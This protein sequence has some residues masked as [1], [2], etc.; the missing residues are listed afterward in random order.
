MDPHFSILIPA[1]HAEQWIERCLLSA[2][3]QDYPHFCVFFV[4]DHSADG[5]GWRGRK[6]I[7]DHT[8]GWRVTHWTNSERR[9]ILA[10]QWDMI[11]RCN[12]EEIAVCLD[13]DDMLAH[14][15]VLSHLAEVYR[16]PNVWLTYGSFEYDKKSRNPE[17]SAA[18]I[19]RPIPAN[20]H[21]RKAGWHCSHLKTFKVWLARRINEE[22]LK[23]NGEWIDAAPD[24]ALM[25]PLIEMAGPEHARF[26]PEILYSYNA[27]NLLSE[28]RIKPGWVRA[29][30]REIMNR[31]VYPRV[32]R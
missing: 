27:L 11:G 25:F 14:P 3:N 20:N 9:G 24:L 4:D 21:T 23:W 26:I 22:D 16:D 5:T 28:S 29:M 7:E 32:E 1:F 31:P 8:A 2:L 30:T 17:G 13:G 10:N 18:G 12:P 15:G 6:I 19:C